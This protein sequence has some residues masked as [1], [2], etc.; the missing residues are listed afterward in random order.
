MASIGKMQSLSNALNTYALR[1]WATL[2]IVPVTAVIG[3]RSTTFPILFK[4]VFT[5]VGVV[6][7]AAL[8][9]ARLQT[10]C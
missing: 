3:F 5:P 9:L 8:V 10:R 6:A 4:H 2:F 7:I 1:S